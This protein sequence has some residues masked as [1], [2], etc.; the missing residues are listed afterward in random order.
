MLLGCWLGELLGIRLGT[1]VALGL[2]GRLSAGKLT[3]LR[4]VL[5]KVLLL[6]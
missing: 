2:F 6:L 3:S 4:L 1:A 5:L